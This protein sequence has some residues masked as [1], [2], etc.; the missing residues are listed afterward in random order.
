MKTR[1][2]ILLAAMLTL[3]AC[4]VKVNVDDR[5]LSYVDTSDV[6]QEM[7]QK[8]YDAALM[9]MA[10][11][12]QRVVYM[13]LGS[14]TVLY[15]SYLQYESPEHVSHSVM[16]TMNLI[17]ERRALRAV[18]LIA[19]GD[20]A[21]RLD[22]NTVLL[23]AKPMPLDDELQ[24][25]VAWCLDDMRE[26]IHCI[27]TSFHE[28]DTVMVQ[29]ERELHS[30]GKVLFGYD[31]VIVAPD[32]NASRAFDRL[33]KQAKEQGFSAIEVHHHEGHHGCTFSCSHALSLGAEACYRRME[34]M[35]Q[36]VQD[37]MVTVGV[38]HRGPTHI[39]C[40]FMA[41]N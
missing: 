2:F 5:D 21:Y 15:N 27:D 35:S 12:T 22:S 11:D 7:A 20:V 24:G 39:C 6:R 33:Y 17:M 29:A 28:T 37:E 40:T 13:R 38:Q 34:A 9:T 19:E 41:H 25:F 16:E 18:E 4:R 3:S 14:D 26:A 30:L 10:D 1:L 8:G 36:A 31:T 23:L 32:C